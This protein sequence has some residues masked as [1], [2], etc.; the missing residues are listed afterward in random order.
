MSEF[1]QQNAEI[2]ARLRA[3]KEQQD[4]EGRA[5]RNLVQRAKRRGLTPEAL[6]QREWIRDNPCGFE[7]GGHG[8]G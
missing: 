3:S 7:L 8:T 4:A 6:A 1:Q 5:R 2:Q